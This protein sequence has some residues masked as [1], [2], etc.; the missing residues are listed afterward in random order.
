MRMRL[1]TFRL[2]DE[3]AAKERLGVVK[4]TNVF[5]VEGLPTMRAFLDSGMAADHLRLDRDSFE[6]HD[7]TLSAPIP[8]P[9]KIVA[10]IVNT[11]AM[12][13]GND[14]RL[15]RPRLDMKAPSSVIGPGQTIYAPPSGIRPEVE[16]AAIVGRQLKRAT[17]NEAKDGI[18]GY[19]VLND[20][21]APKDSKDDA[22]EAYRRDKT[23]GEIRR[24]TMRGPL[25]RSKN[26]DGFCPMGPWVVT[27]EE[28]RDV[29]KLKMS[30][31]FDDFLVQSGSTAEYL[32]SPPEIASYVSGFLTLEPGDVVSCGSI[33]WSPEALGSLDPT[34][35]VLP[36]KAG[37]LTLDIE[38]IG[39]LQ[40]PV[41]PEMN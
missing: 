10:A 12:L 37:E 5:E 36:Q 7:V 28:I 34:E 18:I 30:T 14:L 31:W 24:A 6:I 11:Q 33:G 40:N 15:D 2:V 35:Y 26:H 3:P 8:R 41:L 25:F 32:F 22:Y 29:A 20:V 17:L 21:T 39:K 4:A 13:G 23:T 38:G 19:T 9:G 1:C 27:A 16:M